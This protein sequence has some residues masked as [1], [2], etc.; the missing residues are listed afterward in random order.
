MKPG[1][2][3]QKE[4]KMIKD[5]LNEEL[6][7]EK[8]ILEKLLSDKA[9]AEDLLLELSGNNKFYYRKKGS[10]TRKYIRRSNRTTL[11]HVAGNR[12][13]KA[14]I[15]ALAENIAILETALESAKDYDD[16]SILE[17]LPK[18]YVRAI[19]YLN[20]TE[21]DTGVIQSENPKRRQD[22]TVICS[23]GL[24]VRTKG[25][26]IIAEILITLGI[27]F[28]Y[29]KALTL[30]QR[31]PNGD[32]TFRYKTK[33]I[34]PDFTIFL[35]DG[36]ELYW[37]HAGLFDE[38]PYRS[39]QHERFDLYYDNGIFPPKN[40]IITMDGPGKSINAQDIRRI[41]EAIILPRA[42]GKER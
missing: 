24:R 40:L 42:T 36:T 28:R 39:D 23:N 41:V 22:L 30:V 8:R 16:D 2:L 27:A 6:D 18:G 14:K 37:E 7:F 9:S 10:K 13:I 20:E 31:I 17:L 33:T 3:L 5:I 35:D 26:M 4:G 21:K 38:E 1:F 25:E 15:K 34:Y 29:E 11:R 19:E 12:F 32:G